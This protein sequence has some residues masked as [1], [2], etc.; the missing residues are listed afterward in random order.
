MSER[1]KCGSGETPYHLT[2]TSA[3]PPI[4]RLVCVECH[5][6]VERQLVEEGVQFPVHFFVSM[7][8]ITLAQLAWARR[9]ATNPEGWMSGEEFIAAAETL[10]QKPN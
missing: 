5:D 10:D 2:L 4:T 6:D 1:C 8:P 9:E 3:E 7:C